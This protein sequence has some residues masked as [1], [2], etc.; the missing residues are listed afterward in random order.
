[1]PPKPNSA[2]KTT[3]TSGMKPISSYFIKKSAV[4]VETPKTNTLLDCTGSVGDKFNTEVIV[5][6]DKDLLINDIAMID[7]ADQEY[8][9]MT[10][11]VD[12]VKGPEI[13]KLSKDPIISH[14]AHVACKYIESETI[15][16]ATVKER[17]RIKRH[18]NQS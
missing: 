13:K 2:E 17:R 15:D 1:M 3:N 6:E 4:P 10:K 11:E 9:V 8:G 16:S 18:P 14:S 12:L 7:V 5:I